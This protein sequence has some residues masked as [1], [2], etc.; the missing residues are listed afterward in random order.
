MSEL[1]RTGMQ[2]RRHLALLAGLHVV[3]VL[4]T[5]S[6][7]QPRQGTKSVATPARA[8]PES[9]YVPAAYLLTPGD[10][11]DVRFFYNEEL[12]D[13]LPVRP[14][15][16]ITLQLVGDVRAAG[17]GPAELGSQLNE[18]FKAHIPHPN[19]AVIVKEYTPQQVFVGG[20]VESPGTVRVHGALTTTQAILDRGGAKASAWLS[21]VVLLRY[22]GPG[23]MSIHE[24]DVQGVMKGEV[25]D[26]PLRPYDVLYVPQTRIAILGEY[27]DQYINNIVPNNV[28]FAAFYRVG[29][30]RD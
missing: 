23:E 12:N 1:E 19:V 10:I 14:D 21:Q 18:A 16:M 7:V 13:T 27:V 11:I 24:I 4:G 6:C 2:R 5:I 3:L 26:T 29:P 17:I 28:S 9:P 22:E 8:T 20:E 30:V 15:G 25:A